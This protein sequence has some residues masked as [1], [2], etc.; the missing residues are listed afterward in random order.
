[1]QTRA[2]NALHL[3]NHPIH[4]APSSVS[5]LH[6]LMKAWQQAIAWKPA[7]EW[8]QNKS[9]SQNQATHLHQLC[10]VELGRPQD[11][12]LPDEHALQG[13]DALARLLNVLTCS[14]RM[15]PSV[16]T[17]QQGGAGSPRSQTTGKGMA[18]PS[19]WPLPAAANIRLQQRQSRACSRVTAWRVLMMFLP[20]VAAREV[21]TATSAMTVG[22]ETDLSDVLMCSSWKQGQQ[23]QHKPDKGP[24]MPG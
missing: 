20:A 12:D 19:Q 9:G 3:S 7:S 15:G 11:L 10:E 18:V 5:R 4:S 2:C 8:P 22:K 21:P 13:V 6:H 24:G 23:G 1:M 14:R 16:K 17:Q